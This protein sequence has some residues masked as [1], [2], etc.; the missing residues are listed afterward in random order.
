MSDESDNLT[1]R[2]LRRF[3]EKLDRIADDV[4][5]I[6]RRTTNLEVAV[7]MLATGHGHMQQSFDRM[8]D[9]IERIE[10]RL[11]LVEA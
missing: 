4:H 2:Y 3:D 8:S 7:G 1:H 10:K 5:E 9:R 6:K 11:G